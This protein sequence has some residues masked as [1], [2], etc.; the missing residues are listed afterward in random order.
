MTSA[1]KLAK[2]EGKDWNKLSVKEKNKLESQ[3]KVKEIV[4][5]H[6]LSGDKKKTQREEAIAHHPR[7]TGNGPTRNTLMLEAK[8]RGIKY[9]R[10]MNR[11]ELEKVLTPGIP[12]DLI[13]NVGQQ[14]KERWQKG[15]KKK[16]EG[17]KK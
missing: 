8:K 17:E 4:K 13:L 1:R 3:A 11:E 10:V 15:W 12:Q 16:K 6:N 9:F 14:A 5:K 2:A 7:T